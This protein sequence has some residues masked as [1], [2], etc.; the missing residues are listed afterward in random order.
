MEKAVG[1]MHGQEGV[2]LDLV[3]LG[4]PKILLSEEDVWLDFGKRLNLQIINPTPAPLLYSSLF[5]TLVGSVM[6]W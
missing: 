1:N 3:K 5:L 4:L 2:L 6:S